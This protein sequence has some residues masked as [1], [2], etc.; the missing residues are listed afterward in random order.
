MFGRDE[1][2]AGL[3]ARRVSS[4]LYAIER[5]T[6]T[7]AAQAR[8]AMATY[9]TERS[10]EEQESAFLA[11]L[12]SGRAARTRAPVQDLER[13]AP[14]WAD[15]VPDDAASRAA[16]ARLVGQT[17][18]LPRERVPKTMAALGLD[19]PDVAKAFSRV[20]GEDIGAIWTKRVS[21]S[22][23][24]R[25]WRSSL[26][27]RI[28]SLPPF[29]M[30]FALTVTEA[31]GLGI[32]VLP[33]AL[34]GLG[35]VPGL[36]LLV[37]LG[38]ANLVTVGALVESI[39]RDGPMRYGSA[40]FGRLVTDLLGRAAS[41]G[42]GIGLIA[43]SLITL[44]AFYLAFGVTLS[45][46]TGIWAGAFVAL[47][48]GVNLV[49]LYRESIDA[50]IA[51]AILIGIVNIALIALLVI[52]ALPYVSSGNI[53]HAQVPWV[54]G[55]GFDMSILA[56]VFG[57]ILSA[58]FGHTSAANASKAVLRI[59]PGGRGLLLGNLAA[60]VTVIVLYCVTVFVF[61]GALGPESLTGFGGTVLTPL[62]ELIGPV[63]DLVGSLY[64]SLAIG[65]GSIY[66]ALGSYNQVKEVLPRLIGDGGSGL[67]PSLWSSRWV[68]R[69]LAMLPTILIFL[70][71][72]AL[73]F[74]EF[75]IDHRPPGTRGHA[76]RPGDRWRLP[77]VAHRC[78]T[79]TR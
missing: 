29:W 22:E 73:I 38:I 27:T 21:L 77:H 2:L 30:A 8:Q 10:I 44:L 34:A 40:Y 51:S 67:S 13:Y 78:R 75:G 24:L 12:S 46:A 74:L 16:L 66:Y 68:Q 6:A 20:H 23:R 55:N 56:L 39:T 69:L 1:V 52:L 18:R 4:V 72:E 31:V 47:I 17:Y 5:R 61:L 62:A 7:L 35:P 26:S 79:S 63:V 3:P 57:V 41:I 42:M 59:D 28:E 15:L 33:I 50:T 65:L 25:W 71:V 36:F 49:F 58:Y 43:F 64:V 54:D 37:V 76:G 70:L 32:L 53:G 9:Q 11:A 48:F 14:E 60:L 19:D 45:S